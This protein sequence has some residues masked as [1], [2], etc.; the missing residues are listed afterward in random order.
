MLDSLYLRILSIPVDI[1]EL[2]VYIRRRQCLRLCECL[3]F[4]EEEKKIWNR[5]PCLNISFACGTM[6]NGRVSNIDVIYLQSM[7]AVNVERQRFAMPS[8][9]TLEIRSYGKWL[10]WE[11]VTHLFRF[12]ITDLCFLLPFCHD[13]LCG[14]FFT[15]SAHKNLQ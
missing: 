1:W 10:G 12:P 13:G 5:V 9:G 8:S 7:A 4:E 3:C 15:L 11:F 6:A 14:F 2:K